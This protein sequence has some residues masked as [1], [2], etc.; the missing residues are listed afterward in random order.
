MAVFEVE[1]DLIIHTRVKVR[2]EAASKEDAIDAVAG[3]MPHNH[4]IDSLK[5][6]RASV[7]IKSPKGVIITAGKSYHFEQASGGDKAKKIA[8]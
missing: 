7:D 4:D 6:W 5:G 1:T 2:V 3:I 8:D